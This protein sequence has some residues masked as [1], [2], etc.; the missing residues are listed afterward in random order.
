MRTQSNHR[1]QTAE[2]EIERGK[3]G[4]ESREV[5][6]NAISRYKK[7]AGLATTRD[8][9]LTHGSSHTRIYIMRTPSLSNC[10]RLCNQGEIRV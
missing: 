7:T 6:E 1:E 2:K 8:K 10:E 9:N 3:Q 5:R 4:E